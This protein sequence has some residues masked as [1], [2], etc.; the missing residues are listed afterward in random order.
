MTTQNRNGR[1]VIGEFRTMTGGYIGNKPPTRQT[2]P[3]QPVAKTAA[4]KPA[5]KVETGDDKAVRMA[6]ESARAERVK[7]EEAEARYLLAKRTILAQVAGVP[8]NQVHTLK[9]D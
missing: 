1:P 2:A 8:I 6:I 3:N 7:K 9:H 4:P 5:P